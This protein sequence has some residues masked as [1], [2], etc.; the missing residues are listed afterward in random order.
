MHN[1]FIGRAL[2]TVAHIG[3]GVFWSVVA[4][5]QFGTAWDAA[6]GTDALGDTNHAESR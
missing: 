1:T 6:L 3:L 4:L 5:N 2:S